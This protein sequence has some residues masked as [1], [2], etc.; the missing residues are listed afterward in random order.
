MKL[1][2]DD[3]FGVEVPFPFASGLSVGFGAY[4]DETGNVVRGHF[5][6]ARVVTGL[7]A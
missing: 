6:N 1:Y 3:V 7:D 5:D 2:L 4:V